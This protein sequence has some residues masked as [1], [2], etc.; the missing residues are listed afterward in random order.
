MMDIYP[1]KHQRYLS[2]NFF[3]IEILNLQT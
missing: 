1:I 2:V 3:H